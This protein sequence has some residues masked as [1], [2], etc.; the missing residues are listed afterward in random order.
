M[1]RF[2]ITDETIELAEYSPDTTL[3]QLSAKL[4]E[5]RK[6]NRL[7][8]KDC[9]GCGFCCQDNIP[10]LG[11]DIPVNSAKQTCSKQRIARAAGSAARIIYRF[12]AL[13]CLC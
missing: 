3:P 2:E 6:T 7:K 10:V 8:T 12:W 1:V 13:I 11:F 5:F 9:K 4:E